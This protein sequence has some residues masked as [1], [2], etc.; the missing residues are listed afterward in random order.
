MMKRKHKLLDSFFW[1]F[2]VV[3]CN[4]GLCFFKT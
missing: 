3:S 4:N 2:N 1:S